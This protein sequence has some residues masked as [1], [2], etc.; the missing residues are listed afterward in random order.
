[1]EQHNPS[2]RHNQRGGGHQFHCHNCGNAFPHKPGVGLHCSQKCEA[3]DNRKKAK[4]EES[5]LKQGF[6]RNR[7]A[8]NVFTK[9]GVSITLEQVKLNGLKETL[10]A[11][12]AVKA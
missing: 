4:I 8:P 2:N 12:A 11:H 3:A 5:I 1:M 9:N 6:K 10:K 7:K